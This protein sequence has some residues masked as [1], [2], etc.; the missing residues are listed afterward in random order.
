M[1][2]GAQRS[3]SVRPLLALS[4]SSSVRRLG[5]ER[6]LKTRS[7]SLTPR[8]IGKYLLACQ[9]AGE[10]SVLA[11]PEAQLEGP[12]DPPHRR[13]SHGA[14]LAHQTNPIDRANLVQQDHGIP[15]EPAL[16]TR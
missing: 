2:R 13:G 7:E 10:P 1:S 5:S 14:Q 4:R 11:E 8:S 9:G 15:Q 6:A 16:P 12:I 3:D